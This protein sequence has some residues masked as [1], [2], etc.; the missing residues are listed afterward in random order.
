MVPFV[1]LTEASLDIAPDVNRCAA[2]ASAGGVGKCLLYL[3]NG[4]T[5]KD[6]TITD[7]EG[8]EDHPS[9]AAEL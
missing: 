7:G 6:E 8:W 3:I 5:E 2:L 1:A 4:G 9:P